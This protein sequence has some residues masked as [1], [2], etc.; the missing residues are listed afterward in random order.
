VRVGVVAPVLRIVFRDDHERLGPPA[1]VRER[2][3]HPAEREIVVAPSAAEAQVGGNDGIDRW[4]AA[5]KPSRSV[6]GQD[7][8][9]DGSSYERS[10]RAHYDVRTM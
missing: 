7:R 4:R 1:A 8:R 10:I 3:Y 5:S 2:S 6:I 9:I